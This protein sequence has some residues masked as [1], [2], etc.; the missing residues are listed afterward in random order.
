[1]NERQLQKCLVH[2][3]ASFPAWCSMT[4]DKRKTV[5]TSSPVCSKEQKPL[6]QQ[7][8]LFPIFLSEHCQ[9]PFF[10]APDSA[11]IFDIESKRAAA[12]QKALRS[13]NSLNSVFWTWNLSTHGKINY[14]MREAFMAGV[15]HKGKVL[16]AILLFHCKALLVKRDCWSYSPPLIQSWPIQERSEKP[17]GNWR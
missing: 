11:S 9:S 3:T 16:P 7:N 6:G 13:V 8:N 4:V 14:P 17:C 12:L 2:S 5:K 15:Y 1:M 10:I